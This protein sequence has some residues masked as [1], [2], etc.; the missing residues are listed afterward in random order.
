MCFFLNTEVVKELSFCLLLHTV[1]STLR[2]VLS[3]RVWSFSSLRRATCTAR[4]VGTLVNR[5]TTSKDTITSSSVRVCL[6]LNSF[7]LHTCEVVCPSTGASRSA[8]N[9]DNPYIGEDANDTIGQRGTSSL[10]TF[11]SPYSQPD[12]FV[13]IC[14]H[15]SFGY[16]I[17]TDS[18]PLN[19]GR[20]GGD[21]VS[22]GGPV[23]VQAQSSE[24]QKLSRL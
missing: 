20:Y 14:I 15:L 23:L 16:Y 22:S 2:S 8:R 6:E 24:L 19:C 3:R 12:C 5:D 7:E 9:L 10:C 1:S 17:V 11:G 4:S 13:F 21:K 18:R